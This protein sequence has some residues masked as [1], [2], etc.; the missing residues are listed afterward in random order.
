MGIHW[1]SYSK[2]KHEDFTHN[3]L[4]RNYFTNYVCTNSE[5]SKT[6]ETVPYIPKNT[7]KTGIFRGLGS[8]YTKTNNTGTRSNNDH[9][10]PRTKRQRPS[11]SFRRKIPSHFDR[12]M[13]RVKG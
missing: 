4:I 10:I 12:I 2:V 7:I 3:P 1:A 5:R 13:G 11:R 6:R 9:Q 8:N